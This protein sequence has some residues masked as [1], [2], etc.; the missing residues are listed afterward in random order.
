MSSMVRK[1]LMRLSIITKRSSDLEA[2]FTY[3]L[4]KAL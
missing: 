2:P 4:L 3:T 1:D